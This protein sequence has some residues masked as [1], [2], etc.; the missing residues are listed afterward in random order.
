MLPSRIWTWAIWM[1][2]S[3]LQNLVVLAF[4]PKPIL[5]PIAQSLYYDDYLFYWLLLQC[6]TYIIQTLKF[7]LLFIYKKYVT[8]IE[9]EKF[10]T[11][12]AHKVS[13]ILE[14]SFIQV[15]KLV[16]PLTYCVNTYTGFFVCCLTWHTCTLLLGQLAS[17]YK[18]S[19][20]YLS[21]I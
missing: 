20:Q 11:S 5:G 8:F 15:T 16:T 13:I 10:N 14:F 3:N 19:L 1:L 17:I 4:R 21:L 6:Y 7:L 9:E 12:W 18:P 2:E